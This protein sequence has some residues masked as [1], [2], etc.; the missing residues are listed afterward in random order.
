[1]NKKPTTVTEYIETKPEQVRLRLNELRAYLSAAY[2]SAQEVLKWG[3]PAFVDN[4]IL[5]V[6]AGFT[7]HVS[8]H[9]TP[10][11]IEALSDSLRNYQLS[12]NTI[13]FPIGQTIPEALIN[14]IA[15]LRE[16]QKTKLGIGWK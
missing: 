15:F 12:A 8:L 7:N 3:K 5:C 14:Q 9:P 4:G 10:S 16:A 13:Q 1:M 11:V 6:Y 2:P